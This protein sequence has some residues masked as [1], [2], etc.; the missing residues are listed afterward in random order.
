VKLKFDSCSQKDLEL[1]FCDLDADFLQNLSSRVN[2]DEYIE[3]LSRLSSKIEYWHGSGLVGIL[4]FYSKIESSQ[5]FIS[6]L[7]TSREF[8]SQ[9]LGGQL[10]NILKKRFEGSI[11]DLEVDSANLRAQSFYRKNGFNI[12]ETNTSVFK[13]QWTGKRI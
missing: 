1:Y 10:L 4:C 5:I 3:K 12:V 6:H 9:G 11:I 13:L 8:R 2:L 7:S